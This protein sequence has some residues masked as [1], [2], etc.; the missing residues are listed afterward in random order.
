MVDRYRCNVCGTPSWQPEGS[1]RPTCC[2]VPARYIPRNADEFLQEDGALNCTKCKKNVV[3]VKKGQFGECP[4]CG[5]MGFA[6]MKFSA[7][8]V[9]VDEAAA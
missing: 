8:I 3:P 2:G 7:N 4:L 5:H 6:R 9:Q 1:P